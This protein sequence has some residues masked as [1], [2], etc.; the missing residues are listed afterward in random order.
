M[1]VVLI[2]ENQRSNLKYDPEDQSYSH[3]SQYKYV[4]GWCGDGFE[5]HLQL[6]LTYLGVDVA[7]YGE[8]LWSS[9]GTNPPKMKLL[10]CSSST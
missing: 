1:Y 5:T 10:N 3:L 9:R 6:L 4:I 2:L 8:N 7:Y